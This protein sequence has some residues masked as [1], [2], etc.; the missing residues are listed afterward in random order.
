MI[1]SFKH[2]GLKELFY[3]GSTRRINV[4]HTDKCRLQLDV[5]DKAETLD[6]MNIPT[7]RFHKLEGFKNRYS[8][9]VNGNFR[10]TFDFKEGDA[11]IVDYLDYH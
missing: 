1:N 7:W 10:I 3:K 9:T 4:N 6:D 8:F 5:I 2:K 11:F